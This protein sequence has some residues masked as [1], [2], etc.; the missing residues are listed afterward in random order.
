MQTTKALALSW[1]QRS[2][3]LCLLMLGLLLLSACAQRPPTE[4]SQPEPA[5]E[6][7]MPAGAMS[8]TDL[9]AAGIRLYEDISYTS[10][11]NPRHRLDVYVPER[12][13]YIPMP[14]VIYIHGGN[15]QE[16]DKSEAAQRMVPLLRQGDYA[17]VAINYR[18]TDEAQWPAPLH[19]VKAAIRWTRA[20]ADR[21]HF[22]V[23]RIALW[24]REAGGLLALV[25]GMSNH[26]PD[27]A[28][29]LGPYTHIRSDVSAV[30]NYYGVSDINA[31]LKQSST[32]DR[33]SAQAPEALLIGG[34]IQQHS[35]IAS[36]ASAVH[37]I[38]ASAPPVLSVH[39]NLD[40]QVPVAQSQ[41]LHQRLNDYGI[42][43]YLVTLLGEGQGDANEV[44]SDSPWGQADE[45][46]QTFL[47]RILLGHAEQV[48]VSAIE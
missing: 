7:V 47:D 45:R 23:Q 12:P 31:L 5:P 13:N 20:Q 41:R 27:M 39:G 17:V 42:E 29:N 18:L 19:D 30:V 15:W 9:V 11:D 35:D 46:A 34:G 44:L 28:G 38:R 21:Y 48:N 32:I 26:A 33:A 22:D 4:A 40:Q 14:V 36:A 6:P 10:S 3:Q 25:S 1:R 37:Y 16:G 43:N 24:G 8:E 2:L